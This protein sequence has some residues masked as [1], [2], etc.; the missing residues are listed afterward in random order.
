MGLEKRLKNSNKN[1]RKRI[2]FKKRKIKTLIWCANAIRDNHRQKN[3]YEKAIRE[4]ALTLFSTFYA[5]NLTP[6]RQKHWEKKLGVESGTFTRYSATRGYAIFTGLEY[7]GILE[8]APLLLDLI[9]GVAESKLVD[10]VLEY[11][12]LGNAAVSGLINLGI[13]YP[14]SKFYGKRIPAI[15]AYSGAVNTLDLMGRGI[16]L[17][18]KQIP[19]MGR[20]TKSKCLELRDDIKK[21]YN[22]LMTT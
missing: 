17:G 10:N 18:V 22:E 19:V 6:K 8:I 1:N 9:P 21:D 3:F 5:G 16:L 12:F 20:K 14:L 15:S 7:L 4:V 11:G 2:S 13:R